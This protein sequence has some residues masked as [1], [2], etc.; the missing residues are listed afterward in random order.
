MEKLTLSN[1]HKVDGAH[2]DPA[3][4]DLLLSNLRFRTEDEATAASNKTQNTMGR[5]INSEVTGADK[6]PDQVTFSFNPWPSLDHEFHGHVNVTCQ[7]F[8]DPAERELHLTPLP[9]A[10]ELA[11][12]SATAKLVEHLKRMFEDA[13]QDI[14]VLAGTP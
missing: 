9:G 14:T 2:R 5:S 4:L 1:L 3:D 10:M 6:L 11:E 7:L 13:E 12:R 8:V